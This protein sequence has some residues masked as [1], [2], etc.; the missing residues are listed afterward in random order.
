M[1]TARLNSA[2]NNEELMHL[3]EAWEQVVEVPRDRLVLSSAER[4]A[5]HERFVALTDSTRRTLSSV[6]RQHHRLCASYRLIVDTNAQSKEDGTPSWFDLPATQQHELRKL[7][8]KKERGM[9]AITPD[10]FQ[11]LERICAKDAKPATVTL[12][13]KAKTAGLGRPKKAVKVP[14]KLKA[15]KTPKTTKNPK[16][17]GAT[18]T[19]AGDKNV[20]ESPRYTW[21]QQ[22]WLLFVD[23]WKEAVDEFVD[24][25]NDQREKVK[26][27]N[28]LIRQRFIALGGSEEVTVGSITAKKS[29]PPPTAFMD[30]ELSNVDERVVEALLDA[31]NSRFEQLMHDLREERM[32]ERKQNQSMLLEIL[33][34]RTPPEDPQQTVLYMETLVSKQQEQ[35]MD[36]FMQMQKERHQERE[37]FHA[38]LRQL[39]SQTR[40]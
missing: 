37:D 16:K 15:P 35:L 30:A 17:S 3:V 24:Y 8:G 12:K 38:M 40:S 18:S 20:N 2:W 1:N 32:E 39:C 13:A 28:W 9:T 19:E 5:L 6:T 4:I 36:L 23:A 26:L 33:H 10:L 11:L 27:P 29:T 31:Q 21:T 34:Q 22:D 25:G 14:K 7:H